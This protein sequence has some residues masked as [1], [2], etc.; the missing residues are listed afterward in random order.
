M[1]APRSPLARLPP[2]GTLSW[3]WVPSTPDGLAA[4]RSLVASSARDLARG[5][6]LQ[7]GA[8]AAPSVIR[9][10]GPQPDISFG[11]SPGARRATMASADFCLPVSNR[12]RADSPCGQ[13]GRPPRVSTITFSS[14]PPH[15]PTHP[16]NRKS[17]FVVPCRLARVLRPDVVRVP[18]AENSPCGFLPTPPRDDA[19]APGF[20]FL[21]VQVRR[22][23]SSP[24]VGAC[25][26]HT[27][28]R[29]AAGRRPVRLHRRVSPATPL[30]V[31]Q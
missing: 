3:P 8:S 22:E 16:P 11:P 6:R 14:R 20:R 1:H 12:C 15:L 9:V 2:T 27:P 31:P 7:T 18:R 21:P 13:R 25:R 17:G 29:S 24:G 30:H 19:V 26:A 28:W 23:L 4:P 5:L 10:S